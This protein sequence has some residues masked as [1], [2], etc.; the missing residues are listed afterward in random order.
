MTS[1]QGCSQNVS[2]A[3]DD[4]K[5]QTFWEGPIDV[6]KPG[7]GSVLNREEELTLVK[8]LETMAQMG[9]GYGYAQL[10]MMAADLVIALGKRISTHKLSNNWIYRFL[11]SW[12]ERIDIIKQKG[13]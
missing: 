5:R 11:D 4:I 8:H 9:Y 2:G 10:K 12:K 6:V 13:L 3:S 7:P 1:R